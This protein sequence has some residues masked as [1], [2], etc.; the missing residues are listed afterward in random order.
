M[1]SLH[2][3]GEHLFGDQPGGVAWT[4]GHANIVRESRVTGR[5]L[6]QSEA[7]SDHRVEETAV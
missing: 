6:K 3:F 2:W 4:R 5:G 7:A 1:L